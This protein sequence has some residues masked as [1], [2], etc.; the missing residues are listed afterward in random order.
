MEVVQAAQKIGRT[1][2]LANIKSLVF[3]L[4]V[5]AY[6]LQLAFPAPILGA[7][8]NL[9]TTFAVILCLPFVTRG[10]KAI[11]LVLIFSGAY[12]IYSSGAGWNYMLEA[13]GRN[14][15]LMVLIMVVPVMGLPLRYGGYV[16]VLDALAERY[17]SSRHRMYLVPALFC[18]ILAVFTNLGSVPLTYEITARGRLAG[19]QGLLARSLSRGFSAALFW[20]PNMIVTA[21][22]LTYLQLPMQNYIGLGFSFAIIALAAGF[23]AELLRRRG[24]AAWTDPGGVSR[25]YVDRVKLGQLAAAGAVFLLLVILIETE[26]NLQVTS[27][28]PVTALVL[29]A[30]WLY[31]LGGRES[32][33]EGYGDYFQNRINRYGEEVALFA[34]AGF[35]TGALALS[36][37][38]QKLS[39]CIMHFSGHSKAATALTMLGAIVLASL[40]GIHPLVLVSAFAATLDPAALGLMPAQMALVLIAGW[41]LGSNVS[42]VSGVCL[43]V[44]GLTGKTP[45]EVGYGNLLYIVLVTA[46]IELYM[47]WF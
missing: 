8:V 14:T 19:D 24:G 6:M 13:M 10:S 12:L 5:L 44:S 11:C 34:S 22:V 2:H 20:S 7:L 1:G 23:A 43:T 40:V 37:W 31:L 15:N 17:L 29:P 35:F 47:A 45:L 25:P 41:A 36:G 18:Y 33:R 39:F 21:L 38:S 42:P 30:V 32:I 28:V 9:I 3:T 27:V 46:A 4:M 26:T 16:G